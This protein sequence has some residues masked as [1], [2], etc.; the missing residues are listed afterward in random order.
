MVGVSAAGISPDGFTVNGAK[1]SWPDTPHFYKTDRLLVVYVGHDAGV[2]QALVAA[3]GAQ[4]A[5]G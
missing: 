5:G 1:V 2:I 4:F 3:L